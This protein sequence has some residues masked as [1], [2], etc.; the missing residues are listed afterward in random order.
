M[1]RKGQVVAGV[2]LAAGRGV[3]EVTVL[4][5]LEGALLPFFCAEAHRAVMS[6]EEILA[7]LADARPAV[8]AVDAP[9]TLPLVVA[10]ALRRDGQDTG[11]SRG[12]PHASVGSPYTRQAERDPIWAALGVRPLP[13]SFL[14]GL[15]FRAIALLPKLR[16]LLPQSEVIEVFPAAALRA[17]GI[18][19]TVK[20]TRREA[21][22]SVTARAETH[23]GLARY[24]D[25]LPSPASEPLGADLLDALAAALTAVAYSKGLFRAIGEADEGQIVLPGTTFVHAQIPAVHGQEITVEG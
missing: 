18:R 15:T 13:V 3:T 2:D 17:L 25:G 4:E 23:R 11:T 14:G 7:V 24:I 6:D 9:L 10:D 20:G 8:I 5:L 22:T 12:R 19:P 16:A 1:S 21:K